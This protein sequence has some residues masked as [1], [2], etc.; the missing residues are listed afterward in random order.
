MV[1]DRNELGNIIDYILN[2]PVK[3]KLV[4]NWKEWNYTYIDENYC[5]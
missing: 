3:A 1:R 2:N 5:E 4:N